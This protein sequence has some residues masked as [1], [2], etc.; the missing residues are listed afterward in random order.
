ARRWRR[1]SRPIPGPWTRPPP[2]PVTLDG[3]AG[4]VSAPVA[5]GP[6][7]AGEPGEVPERSAPDDLREVVGHHVAGQGYRADRPEATVLA[8]PSAASIE[9][10]SRGRMIVPPVAMASATRAICSGVTR[11]CD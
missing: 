8:E 2:S 5:D 9:S 1:P 6:W 11:T 10:T 7:Y 4:G 3:P